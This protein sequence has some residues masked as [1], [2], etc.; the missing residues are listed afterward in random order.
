MGWDGFSIKQNTN[1]TKK[2]QLIVSV[3]AFDDRYSIQ[4]GLNNTV[5][6]GSPVLGNFCAHGNN[7]IHSGCQVS[8]RIG[9]ENDH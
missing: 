6:S 2:A 7:T 5:G 1:D 3:V 8:M 4:E 9:L